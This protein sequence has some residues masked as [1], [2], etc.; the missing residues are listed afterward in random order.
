MGHKSA[1][2]KLLLIVSFP[3]PHRAVSSFTYT[4]VTLLVRFFLPNMEK[5]PLSTDLRAIGRPRCT[6]GLSHSSIQLSA[7]AASRGGA[8]SPAAGTEEPGHPWS[9][10]SSTYGP[11]RALQSPG[12]LRISSILYSVTCSWIS[13]GFPRSHCQYM[14]SFLHNNNKKGNPNLLPCFLSLIHGHRYFYH[15]PCYV[16]PHSTPPCLPFETSVSFQV[17]KQDPGWAIQIPNAILIIVVH[18][19]MVIT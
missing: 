12:S 18:A 2:A 13:S 1:T 8:A 9:A 15:A 7:P 19:E 17:E 11:L 6:W 14:L 4:P 5:T 3:P 10:C 16:K